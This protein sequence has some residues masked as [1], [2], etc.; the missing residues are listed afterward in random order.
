[1]NP[2]ESSAAL[3]AL[4]R[5]GARD[6]MSFSLALLLLRRCIQL[7]RPVRTHLWLFFAGFSTLAIAFVP[8]GV[9]L[10]DAFWTRALQGNPLLPIEA[11]ALGLDAAVFA[12][13]G[14]LGPAERHAVLQRVIAVG[15]GFGA[16]ATPLALALYYYQVWIL[17]RL[18]QV[19]RVRLLERLQQLSLRFHA[20]S[21]I[22]DAL[23]RT[24]QDSAMV[25]Q[26]IE[27]LILVPLA[28]LGRFS[29]GMLVVAAFD[30][31]IALGL[32]ALVL[33]LVAI[34]S[35]LGRPLRVG[36]RHARESNAELTSRIQETLAGI[37]V[38]KAYGAEGFEQRRFEAASHGAFAAAFDARARFGLLTIALFWV[39]A[40]GFVLATSGAAL[41]TAR[42]EVLKALGTAGVAAW[43]LGL[44]NYFKLR[45]G[46][47]TS[48]LRRLLRTWGA[49]QDVTIGLD[50]VFELLDLEPEVQ[51]AE[52]A[53][54]LPPLQ[55]GVRFEGVR[56][57]YQ[58]DRPALEGVDFEA[59]VGNVVAIVGATGSG[60]TTLM[61]L[62]L[63]LFDPDVGRVT[64]DGVDLRRF[65]VSSL[66]AGVAVAL[67]ENLLFGTSVRDNIRLA[68][69]DASDA[70]VRAAAKVAAADDFIAALPEAYDTLLG[71]RGTKLSTGQRQRL[72]IARAVLKDAPI[73]ILDEPTAALDAETELRVL[74]RLAAW[75]E[76]RLIFLVTHRLS[77]IR[78]ANQILVLR[79]GR[80]VESGTH[81]ELLAKGGVYAAL[82]AHDGASRGPETA[83]LRGD[84]GTAPLREERETAPLRGARRFGA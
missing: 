67:Q 12:A 79:E 15:I 44:F 63:R 20:D 38:I 32:L 75:G 62:L 76:G 8:I 78:R 14:P 13:D 69:P 16:V 84:P 49:A 33:P 40:I 80:I 34:A 59:R 3:A 50:R 48:S 56:F 28:A 26:L 35:V 68:V 72:S 58:P 21:K 19:L 6:R 65:Q 43:T 1:L 82:A 39:T 30:W 83:P 73:L 64:L 31:R 25:T 60:K 36:F 70:A 57:R 54:P 5:G 47:G 55:R 46:D 45:V 27:V 37:R 71:E 22:G 41:L 77:T 24:I 42:S 61:S 17:Q 51:E 29:F 10:Y 2:A 11:S 52:D 74:E 23:F 53:I 66:R 4:G 9:L 81:A 18:N 7:L